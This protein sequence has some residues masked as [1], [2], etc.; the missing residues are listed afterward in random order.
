MVF[1]AIAGFSVVEGAVMHAVIA[2]W[3]VKVATILTVLS[4]YSTIWLVA[5]SRSFAL[6]PALVDDHDLVFRNGMLHSLRAPR[7]KIAT[8]RRDGFDAAGMKMPPATTPNVRIDFTGPVTVEGMYGIRR[9]VTSVALSVDD[10]D[11][12]EQALT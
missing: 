1:A 11:G 10:P 7:S 12:F 2:E 4:V 9:T 6:R 3:S 5:I 8:V